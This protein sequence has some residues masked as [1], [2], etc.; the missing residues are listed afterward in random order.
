MNVGMISQ[1]RRLSIFIGGWFRFLTQQQKYKIKQHKQHK[2]QILIND[3]LT[4]AIYFNL[5]FNMA[6]NRNRKPD[7]PLWIIL[8]KPPFSSGSI[9]AYNDVMLR[10]AWPN[11]FCTNRRFFVSERRNVA[12]VW[13]QLW[14]E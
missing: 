2:Y 11:C 3:L 9:S 7:H 6:I 12:Y 5:Y 14:I 13:R 8:A 1:L 4:K 10:E